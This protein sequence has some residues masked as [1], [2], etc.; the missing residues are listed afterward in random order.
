MLCTANSHLIFYRDHNSM[1]EAADTNV[2]RRGHWTTTWS[3]NNSVHLINLKKIILKLPSSRPCFTQWY[4]TT[5][6]LQPWNLQGSTTSLSQTTFARPL[7]QQEMLW[8]IDPEQC[9][10]LTAPPEFHCIPSPT[11]SLF[12][13]FNI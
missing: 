6:S 1:A 5:R 12:L 2:L 4:K 10:R 13:T 9:R 11:T 7:I 8:P 3:I